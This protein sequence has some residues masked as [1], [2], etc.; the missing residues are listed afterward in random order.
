M[1]ATSSSPNPEFASIPNLPTITNNGDR[2]ENLPD[3]DDG[4]LF[5][6]EHDINSTNVIKLDDSK[7]DAFKSCDEEP[8]Y[9]LGTIIVRVV[10]AKRLENPNYDGG[11]SFASFRSNRNFSASVNPY[12][13]VNFGNSTQ[14]GS[15]VYSSVNPVFPRD[16]IMFMDVS[17]PLSQLT[18]SYSNNQINHDFDD[19]PEIGD[20][21]AIAST[22]NMK[23]NQHYASI[24]HGD[25]CS[26]YN[27]P[28]NTIL[29]V[30]LFHSPIEMG[31]SDD[32]FLGMASIDLSTL[33]TG[34]R[35]VLD[36]WLP[37]HGTSGDIGTGRSSDYCSSKGGSV[38]IMCEYEPSDVSPKVGDICRFHRL[39]H[40][41]DLY[42]LEPDN[43]Y[44][45]DQVH[46]DGEIVILSYEKEGWV[47]SFQAHKYMLVYDE[48]HVSALNTAQ[49]GLQT[50]GERLSVSPLVVTVTETAERV[51]DDGL[52]GVAEKIVRGSASIFDRWFKGG[53]DTIISDIQD[54][55]N[56]DGRHNQDNTGRRLD[57]ESPTSS[58]SS[59]GGENKKACST[60]DTE[61][62]CQEEKLAGAL[63]NM[64]TC[65]FTGFPMVDPVVATVVIRTSEAPLPDG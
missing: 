55:T 56:L 63:S 51:V 31:N 37:L 12:A 11:V 59:L 29:T 21:L 13:S 40:P 47:L 32:T 35:P 15:E 53:I 65:P 33:L 58:P 60:R 34:Q 28:D 23:N 50:L 18:H 52:V 27:K 17:L 36:E 19:N 1:D 25:L 46:N 8:Q 16:E 62:P 14:R 7:K 4:F 10:A 38:R 22:S 49:D 45:V 26:C 24:S 39:C 5:F 2:I 61:N 64:P 41:K 42:P 30:S 48:R 44:R 9:L 57:L 54:I 43:S 3:A 6:P 20:T